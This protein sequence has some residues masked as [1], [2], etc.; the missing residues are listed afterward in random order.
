MGKDHRVGRQA[1]RTGLR[2]HGRRALPPKAFAP[3][4]TDSMHGQRCAPSLL[5][6]QPRP[7]QTNQIWVSDITYLLL[8][9]GHWAYSCAFQ[10]GCTMHMVDWQVRAAMPKALLVSALQR[11]LLAQRPTLPGTTPGLIVHSDRGRTR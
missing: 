6:D 8:A 2:R 11:A 10:D 9:N 4:T 1:L 3:R 5:L 7:T